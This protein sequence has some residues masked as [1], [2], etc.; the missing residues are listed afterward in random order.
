[1][2]GRSSQYST[3]HALHAS[4]AMC[5]HS[6]SV[7]SSF[8]INVKSIINVSQVIAKGMVDRKKGG[9]IVNISSQASKARHN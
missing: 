9:S 6:L 5:E 3:I 2:T 8:N 1:M 4:L 7:H